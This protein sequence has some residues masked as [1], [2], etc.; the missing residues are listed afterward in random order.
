MPAESDDAPVAL[1]DDADAFDALV[2]RLADV[3]ALAFDLE[4]LSQD[5]YAPTLCLV[6]L[7]WREADR[8]EVRLVDPLALDVTPIIQLLADG[9][10]TVIAHGARQDVG[11]VASQYGV[12]VAGLFDTQ[13][14]AAFVGLGDQPGYARLAHAIVGATIDKESQWTDWDRRPLSARQ[15]RYAIADVAHLPAIHTTLTN[16]LG[17]RARWVH[18]ESAAMI[19]D[20]WAAAQ[21]TPENAWRTFG[22]ARALDRDALAALI[23]LAAWRMR[24]AVAADLPLGH[25]APERAIVEVARNRPRDER[26]L[27]SIRGAHELRARAAEVFGVLARAAE[28]VARGD[29]PELAAPGGPASPRAQVWTELVLA[30]VA[31]A[32]E[33]TGIAPRFLATRADAESLSRAIDR[34]GGLDGVDHPLVS[35]WRRE[36]VGDRIAS[37]FRGDAVV[38][39]DL[40]G[41]VGIKLR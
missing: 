17:D 36:V 9:K 35:T 3:P 7:A 41:P 6:Q 18:A 8:I 10:R 20:A 37:W 28:R 40:T 13:I 38:A 33:A 5:R 16:R 11:L 27:R 1:V 26:G 29:V 23:E 32:A 21:L 30:A 22:G 15:V 39:V 19:E 12:K 4:F 14:A 24:T 2:G 31:E 34:A 25:V